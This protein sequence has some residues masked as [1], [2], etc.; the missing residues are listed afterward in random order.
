MVGRVLFALL[1]LTSSG[2]SVFVSNLHS[3]CFRCLCQ[4]ANECATNRPCSKGYCGPFSISRVYWADAG[5]HVLP[6]DDPNRH[7]AYESCAKDYD[8][9]TNIVA[10]YMSKYGRD[11]NGDGV[12]NCDDYVLIHYNGGESCETPIGDS[13]FKK[14]YNKCRGAATAIN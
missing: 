3:A 5:K 13:G 8:C 2:F 6:E 12:T 1:L 14:R 11:C 4:A 7:G 10:K 9:S